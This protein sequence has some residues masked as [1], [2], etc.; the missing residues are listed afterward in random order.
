ML[1]LW[2]LGILAVLIGLLCWT[3]VGVHAAFGDALTLDVK[4]G[5]FQFQV[6]PVKQKRTKK[7][8]KEEKQTAEKPEKKKP[9]F[10][11]PT[12]A[13][14]Q[15]AV[16]T[17]A[18]PLKRALGRIG[19]DIRIDPLRL[20]LTVGGGED[21]A[22]A[23]QLYGYLHAGVWT[24]MPVLEKLM[25]IP[26][27]AIHIGVDFTAEATAVEGEAGLTARVGTL[28][29]AALGVGVPALRWFLRYRKKQ[30]KPA[31]APEH[32]AA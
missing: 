24:A 2:I 23:A 14:I 28:L 22:A 8:K 13:D 5:L 12:L 9:A 18:P 25:D 21:P 7:S 19:R 27:P 4:I 31:Q 16:R 10:P 29:A 6:L 11:K 1:W 17:L 3:R 26:E 30:E 20:S 32:A 15:D